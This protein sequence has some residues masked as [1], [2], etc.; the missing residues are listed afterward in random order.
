MAMQTAGISSSKILILVGAGLTGSII[1]KNG[2]LSDVLAE[3]QELMKGVNQVEVSSNH[4]DPSLL[5]AQIRHLAQEV[6]D[7]TLSRPVTIVNGESASNGSFASYIMPAA[8]VGAMGY[9]YM[10]WKGWSFSDVMFVTRRNMAVAVANA[11]KQLEQI[12]TAL[13]VTKRH[14]IQ[15]LENLDGK[16]DE[17]KETSKGIMNEVNK[18][19]TDL[20]QIGFDIESIHN[21]VSSLEGKI[22]LLENKQ[23]MTNT[24]IY[25]LCQFAG[26]IKDGFNTNFLKEASS[27]L[28]LNHSS[29]SFSEVEPL[30][31]LQFIADALKPGEHEET[32]IKDT[33]QKDVGGKPLKS[34]FVN[35]T[36]IHRSY[37]R[38]ISLRK[39]GLI[40]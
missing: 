2:P 6:R 10:W 7:L 11:S 30:Q 40:L 25:Y 28:Q 21:M 37:P 16:L 5:A 32:K 27:K 1:L 13:A 26:G 15:R 38:G 19:K 24:G 8:A 35:A 33:L 20:S 9:C 23:D 36:T 34:T 39:E 18:V 3:L 29:P 12:S 22:G 31:G 4:F 14:L 17:Q